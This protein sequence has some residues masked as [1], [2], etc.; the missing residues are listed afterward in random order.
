MVI[1]LPK[2]KVMHVHKKRRVEKKTE[3]EIAEIGLKHV[4]PEYAR[5]FPTKRGLVFLILILFLS[6]RLNLSTLLTLCSERLG[7]ALIYCC[8]C[9]FQIQILGST[10]FF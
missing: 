5:D 4:C 6:Q 10:F 8:G 7:L 2:T 9:C 3:E 1:H